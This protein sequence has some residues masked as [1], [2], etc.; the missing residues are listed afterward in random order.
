ML[1]TFALLMEINQLYNLY[2]ASAGVA[3]DTRKI[4]PNTLFFALKGENF[5]GNQF[6]L[7]ALD[8]G[9]AYAVIDE[10]AY[11]TDNR[12]ILVADVLKTLQ[13]LAHYH[14]KQFD[15]P[16]IA[17]VG[18]NGKTTTKELIR[19][20]LAKRYKV[21]ATQGNLNNH[22]GVPLTLLSMPAGTEMA[23]IEMGANRIGD[24]AELCEIVAPTHG[25]A[26]NVGYDHLEGF[27]SIEGVFRSQT[28]LYQYLIR[29]KGVAVVNSTDEMLGNAAKR[30]MQ[31]DLIRWYGTAEDFA[32]L[33]LMELTPFMVYKDQEQQ[34]IKTNLLGAYN[35]PNMMVA[36]AFGKLFDVPLPAIHQAIAAYEPT[37]N[38][39]Q[40]LYKNGMAVI[41]DAY[42]ANPS[43]MQ[44]AL[45]NFESIKAGKKIAILG[46]M[47]EMGNESATQHRTMIDFAKTLHLT[48]VI[49]CGTAFFQVKTTDDSFLFFETKT[50][51]QH[52][53][54]NNPLQADY[55]LL[56]ASRGIKLETLLEEE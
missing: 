23:V 53:L 37:N 47:F 50:E 55:L 41:A 34:T 4:Q 7:Q 33:Q 51:L 10:A 15:F 39:S 52:W 56:K 48:Q 26:T 25:V 20:V 19:A 40:L 6:A 43:S 11:A 24:N 1:A 54:K 8:K 36:L 3:T 46:D 17:I 21:Y 31:P 28:E 22:I 42:N 18:S 5:N 16:F 45:E 2:R 35:L 29:H 12:C 49:F 9:A 32:Y 14:R 27:G 30:R 38:R 13:D 44:A